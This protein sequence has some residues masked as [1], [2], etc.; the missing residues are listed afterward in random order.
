[1]VIEE[2]KNLIKS[3]KTT[4]IVFWVLSITHEYEN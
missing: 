1:M 2:K 4:K 3:F